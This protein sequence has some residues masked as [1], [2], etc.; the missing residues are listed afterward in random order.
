MQEN[1]TT[2]VYT[3]VLFVPQRDSWPCSKKDNYIKK[4]YIT[5]G[6]I[7]VP[8]VAYIKHRYES[9]PDKAKLESTT[10][11]H[12]AGNTQMFNQQK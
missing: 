9:T 5:H 3:C 4:A 11:V 1:R 6:Y 10:V 8:R 12:F 7:K 2:S